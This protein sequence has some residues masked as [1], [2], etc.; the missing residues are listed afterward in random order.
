[1]AS[2][3]L[4]D[5]ANAV[6]QLRAGQIIA[7]PTEAVFGLGCD[8]ANESAIRKLLS[9]KGRRESAGFVLIA[10]SYS[11]LQPWVSDCAPFLIEKAMQTWPGPV[12]WLFPRAT[13]VPDYVAGDHDTIAV[14]ITAHEPSRDLCEAF[15]SALVSSSANHTAARPARSA[16]E[17]EDYFGQNIAGILAGPLGGAEKPSEIR[18]LVSGRIIRQG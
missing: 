11:Q 5:T 14:R 3:T 16:R 2:H 12:T 9:L 6:E 17:V 18:D 8:P 10:S 7:Y 13:G 1:M 15:G 4:L